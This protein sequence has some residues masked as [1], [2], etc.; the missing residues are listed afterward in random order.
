MLSTISPW[1][2]IYSC[3]VKKLQLNSPQF[4]NPRCC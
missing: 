4:F 2:E 3:L 1:S